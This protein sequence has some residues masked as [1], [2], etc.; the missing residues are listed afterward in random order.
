M[1]IEIKVGDKV[2][3]ADGLAGK[4]TEVTPV[5]YIGITTPMLD[6]ML[7]DGIEIKTEAWEHITATIKCENGDMDKITEDDNLRKFARFYLIGKTILGNKLPIS[8]LDNQIADT[9]AQIEE[10]KA[11][12]AQLRK[13]RWRLETQMNPDVTKSAVNT[14]YKDDTT[15]TNNTEE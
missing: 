6:Y 14:T 11:K 9:H 7:K 10:L 4:V 5:K 1:D 3:R 13:Q 12:E 8:D 2:I 15:K